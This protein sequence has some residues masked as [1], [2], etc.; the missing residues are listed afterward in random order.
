MIGFVVMEVEIVLKVD[1]FFMDF[2]LVEFSIWLNN[3]IEENNN[4]LNKL[5]HI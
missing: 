4:V 5:H 2:P 3:E 1:F